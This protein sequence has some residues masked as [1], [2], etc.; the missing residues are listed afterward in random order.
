[1]P[2]FFSFGNLF[3]LPT[4]VNLKGTMVRSTI[5][6]YA[7]IEPSNQ[8]RAAQSESERVGRDIDPWIV[9][10]RRLEILHS[11]QLD[12]MGL[13]LSTKN[14]CMSL[15]RFEPLRN[16]VHTFLVLVCQR[17]EQALSPHVSQFAPIAFDLVRQGVVVC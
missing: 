8:F 15:I 5:F 10:R 11:Q 3:Q 12:D 14:E 1:L 13:L 16:L 6:T 17:L 4:V 9:W 2:G 7:R